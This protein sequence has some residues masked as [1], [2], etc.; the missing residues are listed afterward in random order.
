MLRALTLFRDRWVCLRL[1]TTITATRAMMITPATLATT[2]MMIV[3]V[4]VWSLRFDPDRPPV[5]VVGVG[6]KV[7][8]SVLGAV[9]VGSTV[10]G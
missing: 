2:A 7:G 1:R 9:V 6:D 8:G 5:D 4:L 3:E 10:V